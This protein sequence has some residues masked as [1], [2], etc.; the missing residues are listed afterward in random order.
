MHDD[1]HLHQALR[2]QGGL[3]STRWKI[4]EESDV[5]F[6]FRTTAR[7]CGFGIAAY[8]AISKRL[9]CGRMYHYSFPDDTFCSLACS[10]ARWVINLREYATARSACVL[11]RPCMYVQAYASRE[12]CKCRARGYRYSYP[13]FP[14]NLSIYIKY[15]Q[16][17]KTQMFEIFKHFQ[18]LFCKLAK[19]LK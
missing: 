8:P 3:G 9:A 5:L 19:R 12:E 17:E 7:L 6:P 18:P 4:R 2:T 1:P 11:S 13:M 15:I 10:L 14:S 16:G